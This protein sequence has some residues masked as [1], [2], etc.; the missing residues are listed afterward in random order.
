VRR[1]AA[2][3]AG[4]SFTDVLRSWLDQHATVASRTYPGLG[5]NVTDREISDLARFLDD[6]LVQRDE[7]DTA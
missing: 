1:N 2:S 5:H 7:P 4:P 6:H 3:N